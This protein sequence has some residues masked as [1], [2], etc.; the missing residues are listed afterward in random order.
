MVLLYHICAVLARFNQC[1]LNG[2]SRSVFAKP[3]IRR[4]LIEYGIVDPKEHSE[5]HAKGCGRKGVEALLAEKDGYIDRLLLENQ[6]M[7]QEIE[8]LRGEIHLL[9]YRNS[10]LENNDF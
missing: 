5:I 9:K 3:H 8:L 6:R 10:V 7:M 4:V 1:F 2:L